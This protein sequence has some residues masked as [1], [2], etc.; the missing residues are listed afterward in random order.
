MESSPRSSSGVSLASSPALHVSVPAKILLF[1]EWGVTAGGPAVCTALDRR[2]G[3]KVRRRGGKGLRFISS[4]GETDTEGP[5]HAVDGF[6]GFAARLVGALSEDDTKVWEGHELTFE[7]P[8]RLED[9]LGSSSAVT[10]ALLCANYGLRGQDPPDEAELWKQGRALLR[11]FQS[12]RASGADLAAQI[13]GGTVVL[14]DETIAPVNLKF[15][16]ELLVVHT[17]RKADTAAELA[18]RG[19]LPADFIRRIGD[20]V[21][22]FLQTPDWERAIE[23]HADLLQGLGVVPDFVQAAA[24]DW[25]KRGWIRTLKTTGAGGGDALLVWTV[26]DYRSLLE[27]DLAARGWCRGQHRLGSPGWSFS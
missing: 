8:W 18:N 2:L 23:E 26:P 17:G 11:R 6:F 4:E 20:S 7:R 10:V 25:K 22:A 19:A 5:G 15:P 9:G 13:Y 27:A 1:G 24:R 16:Q 14:S 21:R 3:L 12:A